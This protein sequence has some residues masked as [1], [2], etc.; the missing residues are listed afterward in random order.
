MDYGFARI[1][2]AIPELK[3][4][5]CRFNANKIIESISS[6]AEKGA[7]F[8]VFPELSITSYSCGDLFFQ[9]ALIQEAYK[10]LERIVR[11]TSGLEIVVIVGIPLRYKNKLFSCGAVI[12]NNRIIGIVP[13]SCIVNNK[14]YNEGRWF[15][16]ASLAPAHSDINFLGQHVPFGKNLIFN[17]HMYKFDKSNKYSKVDGIFY[18]LDDTCNVSTYQ[19]N[20]QCNS[21]KIS[22]INNNS[23]ID[24]F[25]NLNNENLISFSIELG[26]DLQMVIPPSSYH[27][28]AG[29][30][31]IFNL[32]AVM[33]ETGF[34]EYRKELVR[35]QSNKCNIIY[36]YTSAGVYESTTDGVFGGYAAIAENGT[37]LSENK[38]FELQGRII[39]AD[40]DIDK[41]KYEKNRNTFFLNQD[42]AP[43]GLYRYIDFPIRV[44]NT[45]LDLPENGYN[46]SKPKRQS[47]VILDRHIDPYP[48]IPSDKEV[49]DTRYSE[50]LDIQT[51]GLVI[52]MMRTGL[53]RAIIGISGGLDS[54]LAFLV[55]VRAFEKLG[56][57][58]KDIIA[59]TMPGF[60]TTDITLNSALQLIEAFGASLRKIDIK[61]ACLQHFKD[62]GH[63]AKILDNTYEN[64]QARERTQILMDIANKEGGLVI[65]TGDLSELALGWCTYNGDHM[66]MYAVNAGLPKTLIRS[67]LLWAAESIVDKSIKDILYKIV[68]TPIT[69]ELLP[70]DEMGKI[71]QKTEDIV[72]PYELHDFFL[73]HIVRYGVAPQ[74][75]VFLAQQAFKDK[76]PKEEIEKWLKT[77]YKRFYTQQFKRSC[78]PDGPKVGTISLSP[79]GG[80][81]MPSDINIDDINI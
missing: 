5:D 42:F 68:D 51:F 10:Q 41:I 48:F 56:L 57:P 15:S 54:T 36:A 46:I 67:L 21:I 40:A 2:C 26:S 61:Q 16:S 18:K 76:Y 9:D 69:P 60:G 39:Y 35:L 80:W 32:S 44:Y 31:V 74:K 3:I 1:A 55:T 81:V 64:V 8:I 65:G 24:D 30:H 71:R 70:P 59:I 73:Y 11:Y 66:S 45:S 38:R 20:N 78:M 72:G 14:G 43:E 62:I 27:S 13:K 29:A 77:F 33:E 37:I 28:M 6:A 7:E 25:S 34:H 79:R 63:D 58:K 52:R 4:A 22:D 49:K 12:Q 50:I 19:G 75:V 17:A 53:K 47:D 23:N